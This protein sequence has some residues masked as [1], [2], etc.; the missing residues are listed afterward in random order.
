MVKFFPKRGKFM[1]VLVLVSLFCLSAAGLFAQKAGDT[2]YVNVNSADLKS[3][4]GF[5]GATAGTVRYG[6]QV[7]VR[8][9]NGKWAQVRTAANVTGW[10]VSA[11]LTTKKIAAQGNTAN[12]S[13]REISLA[14]KGFAEAEA[15]YKKSDEELDYAAVDAMEKTIVSNK[16]L[17]AFIEE[18]HLSKGE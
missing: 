6:D 11:N 4:A 2:M 16:D 13:A 8:A 9:V 12:A 18:G 1:K 14:G 10:V 7:S 5:F 15:E 3:S 17:L